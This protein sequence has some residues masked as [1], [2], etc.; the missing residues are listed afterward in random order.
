MDIY[1]IKEITPG[2]WWIDESGLDSMY[3]IKGSKRGLVVDTGTGLGDFKNCCV[4][5]LLDV[6]YDV[7]LTHGHVDH[8]GGISQF[9]KVFIHEKDRD[10]ADNI[11]LKDRTEYINRMNRSGAVQIK[12]DIAEGLQ[13]NKKPE[14]IFI[15]EGDCFDLGDR[16]VKTAECPGH[17]W[18]SI[19]LIDE[20]DRILFSGDNINDLELICAP[21]EDRT[22]LLRKWYE[23]ACAV[24]DQK[25]DFTIC[26]G[27]HAVFS[28]KKA[29]EVLE[30]G[31]RVL[32]GK[33]GTQI[34]QVHLFKGNFARYKDSYII[35]ESELEDIRGWD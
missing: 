21:A 10:M 22:G 11:S 17:T 19:C 27:G 6:P 25:A 32:E 30:C 3:I 7:V 2:V 28:V 4:K 34:M 31:K 18:G 1:Q 15:K 33:I 12:E 26:C 24:I 9:E 14:Y 5:R 16:K 20:K 8:A 23:A 29:E 13:N 35:F